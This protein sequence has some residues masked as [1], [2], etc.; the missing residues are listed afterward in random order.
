MAR[1]WR[2]AARSYDDAS[3]N[4]ISTYRSAKIFYLSLPCLIAL[5]MI[6]FSTPY[7]HANGTQQSCFGLAAGPYPGS[8]SAACWAD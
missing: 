5:P 1:S 2:R 3:R 7:A 8:I 6:T 4:H